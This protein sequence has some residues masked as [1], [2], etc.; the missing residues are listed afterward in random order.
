MHQLL[1]PIDIKTVLY[2]GLESGDKNWHGLVFDEAGFA[3]LL[4]VMVV[5]AGIALRRWAKIFFSFE[6]FRN[7][8]YRSRRSELK[9][10]RLSNYEKKLRMAR[11]FSKYL[12]SKSYQPANY[13]NKLPKKMRHLR[14]LI[15]ISK[16]NPSSAIKV[17]L[18]FLLQNIKSSIPSLHVSFHDDLDWPSF[19]LPWPSFSLLGNWGRINSYEACFVVFALFWQYIDS[20]L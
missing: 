7:F 14:W 4:V 20:Y 11:F 5:V 13:W 2:R 1:Y 10:S 18:N 17:V 8:R 3:L 12:N 6:K 16:I 19:D 9:K 15:E